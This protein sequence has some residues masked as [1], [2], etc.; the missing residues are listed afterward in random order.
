MSQPGVT[1]V[2]NPEDLKDC[3]KIIAYAHYS[4]D[5]PPCLPLDH[6]FLPRH[7][8]LAYKL[9]LAYPGRFQPVTYSK[10]SEVY[11]KVE[12]VVKRYVKK[13]LKNSNYLLLP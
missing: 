2:N 4:D 13:G 6:F 3:S 11:P 5:E 9:D 1:F 12:K 7:S 10:L 8:P